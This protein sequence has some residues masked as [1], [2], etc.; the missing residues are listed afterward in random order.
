MKRRHVSYENRYKHKL[1]MLEPGLIMMKIVGALF[2]AG[3]LFWAAGWQRL[4][5]VMLFL[6]GAV[7]AAL[8]LLL[9]VEAHQDKV[10]NHI[11]MEE[12]DGLE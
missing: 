2:L 11:A 7:F 8:L 4:A 3:V 12:N 10:L 5:V 9:A 6:A 1:N